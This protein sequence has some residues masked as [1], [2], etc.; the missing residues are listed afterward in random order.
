MKK[1]E[2]S[3]LFIQQKPTYGV[4]G[5]ALQSFFFFSF[6]YGRKIYADCDGEESDAASRGPVVGRFEFQMK[7]KN[8]ILFLDA[9]ACRR[10]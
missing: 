4:S 8:W 3:A 2:K 1:R 5:V 7:W 10:S 6:S 9:A